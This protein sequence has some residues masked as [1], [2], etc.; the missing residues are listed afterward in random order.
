MGGAFTWSPDVGG[1]LGQR[2]VE[3]LAWAYLP[4]CLK[5]DLRGSSFPFPSAHL[6]SLAGVPAPKIRLTREKCSMNE[7]FM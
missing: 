2:G 1:V 3:D 7:L 5:P 4:A 6:R